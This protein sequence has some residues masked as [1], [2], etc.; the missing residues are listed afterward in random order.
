MDDPDAIAFTL[1]Q[2]N[3]DG[4]H[5]FKVGVA[6]LPRVELDKVAKRYGANRFTYERAPDGSNHYHGNL[7]LKNDL[8]KPFKRLICNVLAHNAEILMR[9]DEQLGQC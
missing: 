4:E 5:K 9:E 3:E 1:D 7:L 6:I 2:A 8:P